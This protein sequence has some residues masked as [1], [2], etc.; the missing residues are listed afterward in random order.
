[1]STSPTWTPPACML[2]YQIVVVR[3]GIPDQD[4]LPVTCPE[5]GVRTGHTAIWPQSDPQAEGEYVCTAGHRWSDPNRP[6]GVLV[7]DERDCPGG[8]SGGGR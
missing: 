4:R 5:C 2:D 6:A 7:G 1:M 8:D 3:Q